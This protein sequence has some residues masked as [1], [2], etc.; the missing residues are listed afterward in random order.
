[1]ANVIAHECQNKFSFEIG[2]VVHKFPNKSRVFLFC[3]SEVIHVIILIYP[4]K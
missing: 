1:M 4:V 2:R 3:A